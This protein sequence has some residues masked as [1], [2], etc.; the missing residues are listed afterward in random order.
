MVHIYSPSTR[1]WRTSRRSGLIGSNT[2]PQL[3]SH[4]PS[5]IF[6][7]SLFWISWFYIYPHKEH[8]YSSDFNLQSS[9]AWQFLLLLNVLNPRGPQIQVLAAGCRGQFI[10]NTTVPG[11]HSHPDPASPFWSF[12]P[13]L[14]ARLALE[15]STHYRDSVHRATSFLSYRIK[16]CTA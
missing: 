10:A 9:H 11:Y 1:L 2:S 12:S 4:L 5:D 16:S 7:L 3:A 8:W 15:A 13:F 6:M 14:D